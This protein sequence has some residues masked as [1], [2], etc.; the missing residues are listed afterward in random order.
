VLRDTR[1]KY[2]DDGFESTRSRDFEGVFDV[3]NTNPVAL[4]QD[5]DDVEAIGLL[6]AAMSVDP[7]PRGSR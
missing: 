6:R 5:T 3:S 4:H 2:E 7:H 1:R